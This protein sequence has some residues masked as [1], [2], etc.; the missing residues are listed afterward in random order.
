MDKRPTIFVDFGCAGVDS[1]WE[2][3]KPEARKMPVADWASELPA[4]ITQPQHPVHIILVLVQ[5]ALFGVLLRK[6][7]SLKKSHTAN[8]TEVLH[9]TQ[10]LA[11]TKLANV[12]HS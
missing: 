2:Q 5:D 1:A 6:T 10:S 12:F 9:I 4:N 7:C 3:K 11:I 8:L